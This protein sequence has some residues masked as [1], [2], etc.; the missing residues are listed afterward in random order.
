MAITRLHFAQT[1]IGRKRSH[2][3]DCYAAEPALGLYVV[4]DGMGGGNAGEVAS[5]MAIDAI[6]AY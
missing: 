5:H 4:C 2:N 1:D 3:E 6:L